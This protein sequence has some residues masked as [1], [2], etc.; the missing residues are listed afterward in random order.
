[1]NCVA[2]NVQLRVCKQET[3]TLDNPTPGL[4]DFLLSMSRDPDERMAPDTQPVRTWQN[5]RLLSK[6][7]QGR[8]PVSQAT[9]QI[10]EALGKALKIL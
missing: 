2:M 5:L 4:Q 7:D 9:H 3:T 8:L 1:M 6:V 10:P